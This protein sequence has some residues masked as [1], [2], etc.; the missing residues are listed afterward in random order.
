[1]CSAT[2][3]TIIAVAFM[4]AISVGG[5]AYVLLYPF[6]SGEAKANKRM[7]R[8]AGGQQGRTMRSMRIWKRMAVTSAAS[9]CKR[10]CKEMEDNQKKKKNGSPCNSS[11]PQAG[12]RSHRAVFWML[13]MVCGLFFGFAHPDWAVC[14]GRSLSARHLPP[15]SGCRAGS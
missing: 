5:V 7:A 6:L 4:A 14:N 13:S 3:V 9:R 10:P 12:L 1:M 15:H 2:T 8:V 11:D